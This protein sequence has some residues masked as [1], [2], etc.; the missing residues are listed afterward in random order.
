MLSSTGHLTFQN[1]IRMLYQRQKRTTRA[2]HFL[3][4][5]IDD[6]ETLDSI[7]TLQYFTGL[8]NSTSKREETTI[9]DFQFD[10][11]NNGFVS[12]L[13]PLDKDSGFRK[14]SQAKESVAQLTGNGLYFDGNKP[15]EVMKAFVED[16]QRWYVFRC[17]FI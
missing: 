5:Q 4:V 10:D 12:L 2:F 17:D 11:W 14:A 1:S 6:P 9:I 7:S 3:D 13:E 8:N 16:E 15:F